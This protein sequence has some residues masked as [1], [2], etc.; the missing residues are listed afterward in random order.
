[1]KAKQFTH[2][3]HP[4]ELATPALEGLIHLLEVHFIQN[5]AFLEQLTNYDLTFLNPQQSPQVLL[6]NDLYRPPD[7][8]W[9]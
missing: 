8:R 2:L 4:L 3:D 7:K 6:K 1:M 5:I 9:R